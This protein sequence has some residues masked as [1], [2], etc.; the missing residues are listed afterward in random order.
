MFFT[1]AQMM[2]NMMMQMQGTKS[3]SHCFMRMWNLVKDNQ[4]AAWWEG[5]FFN[6]DK[7]NEVKYENYK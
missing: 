5:G 7:M 3:G 4:E 6:A 1:N 2:M